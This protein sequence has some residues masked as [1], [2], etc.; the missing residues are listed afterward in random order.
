MS[1]KPK[2]SFQV[3]DPL[4]YIKL[5]PPRLHSATIQRAALLSRLD[6]GLAKKLVLVA[7]P[8]GFGKTTLLSQWLAGRPFKSAW[9]TLDESDN[10]PVRF[11]TYVVSAM[12]TF[13]STVGKRS[14]SLLTASALPSFDMILNSL[15]NDSL[16]LREDCVLVLEDYQAITSTEVHNG[17]S[18]LVQHLPESLHLVLTTRSEPPLPLATLRARDE[19]I[20]ANAGDLRFSLA[21]TGAFLHQALSAEL[22]ESSIRQLFQKTQGWPAGLRLIALSLRNKDGLAAN[23]VDS[24]SGSER[25][26][27]DYL[28]QEVFDSRP[29]A[30]QHFLLRTCFLTRL[31][32]SLC[33]ELTGSTDGA[34]WLDQ[35][36]RDNLFVI[37]LESVG[38]QTWYRYIPL[39]A[40]SIQ[41]LAR[42]K[43]GEAEIHSMFEKASQWYEAHGLL[44]EAIETAITAGVFERALTWIEKYIGIHELSEMRTLAR[45]LEQIPQPLLLLHPGVCFTYAAIILYSTDRFAPATAARIEPF[46]QAAETAWRAEGNLPKL[47]ELLSFR[48][49]VAWWQGNFPGAVEYAYRSLEYILEQDLLWRGNSLLIVA[50]DAL[51]AGQI[52][53]AQAIVPEVRARMGA[54][55]NI[56]GVLAALQLLSEIACWQGES[57]QAVEL[58]RQILAEAVGGDEMLDDKGI[59]SLGLGRIA[60]E[61]NDLEHAQQLIS[62]ALDFALARAN[63]MLQVQAVIYLAWIRAAGNDFQNADE[64]LV[65]LKTGINN[66]T[67]LREIQGTQA[68]LAVLSGNLLLLKGWQ[69]ITSE[70]NPGVSHL[71]KEREA[72]TLARLQIA[73]GRPDEALASLNSWKADAAAN[74]RIRSQVE[75]ACLEALAC[76]A[77]SN[78]TGAMQPAVEALTLGSARGFRR[79][80]LDEGPR[81]AALLQ[82]ILPSLPNRA[83]NSF[84]VALLHSFP[85]GTT[86]HLSTGGSVFQV[87]ALSQQELRVLRLLVTGRSNA[88]I[89]RELVVSTNTIKTHVKSIYRKLNVRRRT[90][91]REVAR[92]L[93]LL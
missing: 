3:T 20:E 26:I 78:L 89:A 18:F 70:E 6:E 55:Q 39:F 77:G 68:R 87:E 25:H 38:E 90:E 40:E 22:P 72:F 47:G 37:Q 84:V 42:R 66:A 60:Y 67:L 73:E 80:F 29:E 34:A 31:T 50:Q 51:G 44:D 93:K 81:M 9:V 16:Q 48:G 63:E 35:L 62:Q 28:I 82:A 24:I 23:R 43:F 64:L 36:E 76:H 74:G 13:D 21:E 32:G 85:A 79:L 2:A 15:I 91:V 86:G 33:N 14:L 19:M 46:L 65:S 71:Q 57:E 88:E 30:L 45:W 54:A 53:K 56:H 92:E 69:S 27:A 49:I 11:W 83:L 1:S 8:A 12:R 59:A 75:A 10:D 41:L 4:L 17:L 61:Q 7:A 52:L 58:N 5:T